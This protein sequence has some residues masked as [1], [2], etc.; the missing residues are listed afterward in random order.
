MNKKDSINWEMKRLRNE[1]RVKRRDKIEL[2]PI[3][4][5]DY[6]EA[7]EQQILDLKSE[8]EVLKGKKPNEGTFSLKGIDWGSY[9]QSQSVTWGRG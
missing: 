3:E 9:G 2:V 5:D 1:K 6:V 7:L 8:I 4:K